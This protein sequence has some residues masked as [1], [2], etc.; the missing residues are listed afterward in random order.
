MGSLYSVFR[1]RLA[2]SITWKCSFAVVTPSPIW[3]GFL[4][5]KLLVSVLRQIGEV[6]SRLGASTSVQ[7]QNA[8]PLPLIFDSSSSQSGTASG[9]TSTETGRVVIPHGQGQTW[10]AMVYLAMDTVGVAGTRAFLRSCQR[11]GQYG[12]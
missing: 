9:G 11:T 12:A 6:A 1:T 2:R 7:A 3:R 10:M 5:R 4:L 8:W